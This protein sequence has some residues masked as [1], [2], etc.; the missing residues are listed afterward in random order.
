[1]MFGWS[2]KALE[3]RLAFRNLDNNSAKQL[4]LCRIIWTYDFLQDIDL[5]EKHAL[6]IIV[7][8]TLAKDLD[9]TLGTWLSVHA[10]A[11]LSECAWYKGKH[12]IS[13]AL[14]LDGTKSETYLYREPFQ[15]YSDHAVYPTFF[16]RSQRHGHH[17]ELFEW[18]VRG[19]LVTIKTPWRERGR[20]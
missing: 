19:W 14:C 9:G 8:V 11:H 20:T 10:H 16:Q 13:L 5:I 12:D 4:K 7:H 1:M 17:Y 15:S 2:C 3:N 18:F 6:L